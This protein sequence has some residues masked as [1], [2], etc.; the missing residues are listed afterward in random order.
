VPSGRL[1]LKATGLSDARAQERLLSEFAQHGIAGERLTL[2]PMDS[3]F[4]THLSRYHDVDI[5][6]DPFPYNGTTTTL[7]ALWMGVPVIAIAGD[8]HGARVGASILLNA[9]LED[10]IAKNADD[11]V[12]LASHLAGDSDRLVQL[13]ATMRS[14]VSA[15]ALRDEATFMRTL[16]NAYRKMWRSWCEV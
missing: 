7:E 3:D 4:G 13:R 5:G 14:R 16:E 11:C 9:G 2:L 15:S 1:L 8:R 10:L 12:S 6:L